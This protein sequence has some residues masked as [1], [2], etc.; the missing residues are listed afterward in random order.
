MSLLTLFVHLKV[1]E[2]LFLSAVR[3]DISKL[4]EKVWKLYRKT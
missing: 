2:N 4:H 1:P 3:I